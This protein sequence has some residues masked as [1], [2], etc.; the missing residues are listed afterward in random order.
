MRTHD[1]FTAATHAHPNNSIS[2]A[3]DAITFAKFNAD[4]MILKMRIPKNLITIQHPSNMSN[5]LGLS[6][7]QHSCAK[8]YFRDCYSRWHFRF[9]LS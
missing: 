8:H 4:W 6:F 9:A 7:Y 5:N 1:Q 3:C 2:Q